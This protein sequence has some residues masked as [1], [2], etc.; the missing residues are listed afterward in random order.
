[1]TLPGFFQGTGMPDPDWWQALWPDPA[2]ILS[3]AGL[4]AGMRAIDL[5]A[6]DGWFT[7]PMAQLAGEVFAIDIDAGLLA[8]ARRRLDAAGVTNARFIKG[9][10]FNLA[11]LVPAPMDFVFLGNAF[12]GVPDRRRLADAVRDSLAPEGLFAI[13]NW[14]AKPREETIVLGAPRGPATS[15]RLP[16]EETIAA[17][18]PAGFILDRLVELPPYH[19]AA[20]FRVAA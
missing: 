2:R 17:V 15:L 4:A 7:L 6:G 8:E 19:Y 11:R 3:E 16:P 18:A 9:D 10:A 13:V 12:H 20:V 5:C 1:M 14:H